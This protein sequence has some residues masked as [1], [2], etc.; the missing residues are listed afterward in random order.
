MDEKARDVKV[1]LEF[2]NPS[3]ELKPGMY[4]NVWIKTRAIA[5]AILVPSEA[6]IRTGQRN[7]VFVTLGNGRFEPREVLIGEESDDGKIRIVSGL[8]ENEEVVISAQFL[9][10]SESRLQEVIQKMLQ[11]INSLKW[12]F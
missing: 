7:L 4:A 8:L 10:D 9:I 11:E 6:V 1:R 2:P 5:D 12:T 3:L